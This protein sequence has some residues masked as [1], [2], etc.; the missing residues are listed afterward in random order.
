MRKDYKQNCAFFLMEKK[1]QIAVFVIVAV[2]ILAIIGIFFLAQNFNLDIGQRTEAS[3]SGFLRDCIEPEVR[4]SVQAI[5]IQGGYIEPDSFVSYENQKIQYLCYTSENYKPCVV[6]QPLLVDH[7]KKE[8]KSRVEPRAKSCVSELKEYYEERGYSVQADAGEINVDLLP[9]KIIVDFLSPVT[10]TKEGSQKFNRFSIAIDSE[11][12]NLLSIATSI[13]QFESSLGDSETLLYMQYYPDLKI[14]KIRKED[15]KV[16]KLKNVVSGDE[17][18][19]AVRSLV[20][21]A[22]YGLGESA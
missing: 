10:I 12:Y 7:V 13:I 6:Q 22:G 21:P 1:G 20:W 15:Y 14:E 9:G 16:Y 19:F 17:F 18:N 8:I 3:P 11:I 5:S 4:D 2:L